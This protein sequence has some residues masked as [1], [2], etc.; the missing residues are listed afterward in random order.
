MP[1]ADNLPQI[2]DRRYDDILTEI[3][4]RIARYAPEWRP[5]ESAWTD[6]NDNDPGITL[7]QVFAWQAEMLLYRMNKVPLLN[8]LKFLQLIGIE[9]QPAQPALA[10]VTLPLLATFGQ[11]HLIIPER[12]QLG[13]EAADGGPPLVYE[14]VRA[15]TA[16]RAQLDAVLALDTSRS[17]DLTAVNDE[18]VQGFQPFGPLAKDGAQI[19][20]GFSDPNPLPPIE[21][22]LAV[23]VKPDSSPT[24]CLECGIA[25]TAAYG[26]AKICWEYWTG[27]SWDC[28]NL[29]KDDTLGF[30]RSGHVLLKLPPKGIDQKTPLGLAQARF[31][32]RARLERGQYER[33]P[34]VL[35]IRTN[36]APVEQAESL[37]D[38]IIGGSDGSRNQRF[39][40]A[41]TPVLKGSLQL[42]VQQSDEGYERWQEVDDFFGSGPADKHYV[43]NR[44]SGEI[45]T[46]DGV[47]GCIP[48][49][50]VNNPGANVVARRYRVGGGRRG[51]VAAAEINTLATPLAGV[52]TNGV[53]NLLAAYGGRDEESI[54]EAKRRAP[55]ALKSRCRAVTAEDF[56]YLAQ[57]AAN[58]RRAKALPLFHPMFPGARI[59]GVVSVIVVPD[60]DTGKTPNPLPSDATLRTVCAYLDA[61]RL[62]TTE[63]FVLKPSYQ[64]VAI[65]GELVAADDA[66]LAQV[67]NAVN[68][69][70]LLYFDPLQGGENGQGWPFGGTIHY[71]RV[72]HRV[73]AVDGVASIVTLTI[74]LDGVAQPGCTDIP[75]AANGL[76]YSTGHE[77]ILHYS[78]GEGT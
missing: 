19:A 71:S 3:R 12:T 29:L 14:T 48:V 67:A 24:A 8:Y 36:S 58:V 62:L 42:D 27:S 11:T 74:V 73:F 10:E 78:F 69:S 47:N 30:T 20:L 39:Q 37:L 6:V 44:T 34:E 51:N 59:P 21:L 32:I 18:A 4:T 60:A 75:L 13:A 26:P 46:G 5:G 56:E 45:L 7:A 61:R 2:D 43:L 55:R 9:L 53:K 41:S 15:F 35:A 23:V 38:E 63:L 66:D 25:A 33:A 22:D 17:D 72:Y 65:R 64:Q 16:L 40:L 31:W 76:L 54:D 77:V 1:L 50:Y 49:A 52:D 68:Q 57:Q 70:L 28:L